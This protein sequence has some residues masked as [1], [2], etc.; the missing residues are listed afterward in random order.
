M[1]VPG[2]VNDGNFSVPQQ[3]GA[4]LFDF[5][6]FNRGDA[7]TFIATIRMRC[8]VS[9]FKVPIP[10]SVKQFTTFGKAFLVDFS[11]PSGIGQDLMEWT[12]VYANVPRTRKEPSTTTYT[13]Q[14]STGGGLTVASVISYTSTMQA[15]DVYEYS[16]NA[17]LPPLIAPV[18]LAS[19]GLLY[20]TAPF[21]PNAN[22]RILA[23]NSEARIYMGKI[24]ERKSTYINRPAVNAIAAP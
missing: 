7:I 3:D 10:M 20:S 9:A 1:S 12:Q 22:T 15:E 5:P 13:N 4:P 21:S 24:Y 17:P 16:V 6:F 8:S 23:Q 14:I 2:T 18:L 11:E 19:G